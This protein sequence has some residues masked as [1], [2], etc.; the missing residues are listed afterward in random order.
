MTVNGEEIKENYLHITPTQDVRISAS[1]N[2]EILIDVVDG[3]GSGVYKIGDTVKISAPDKDR[4]LFLI[5]DVF[6]HW[7]GIDADSPVVSFVA[8]RDSHIVA[9]YRE[10]YTY[11]MALVTVPL[12]AGSVFT[13]VKNTSSVRW[14]IQNMLEK[15]MGFI[16]NGINA[17]KSKSVKNQSQ[18]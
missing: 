4:V 3:Q 12:I 13:L 15:I 14:R 9:V 16:P 10:D 18:K 1:Y 8:S 5:R 6:D 17:K 11:L 2:E 7:E